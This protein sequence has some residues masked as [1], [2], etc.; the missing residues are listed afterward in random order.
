[1]EFDTLIKVRR[2]TPLRESVSKAAG[3]VAER[4]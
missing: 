3:E 4:L 2:V 1:M